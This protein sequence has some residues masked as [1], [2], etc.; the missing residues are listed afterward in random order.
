MELLVKKIQ[1]ESDFTE[2][3][4]ILESFDI[5]NPFYR[6]IDAN[7]N[8]LTEGNLRCFVMQNNDGKIIIVMPFLLRKIT[9][10]NQEKQY[11][12]VISPYGYS[13][14]L[15]N[16]TLSRGWL[17][18]FWELVD[19]WYRDNNVVSEFIRFNLCNNY[20][21]YTGVL[22][23]TLSNVRGAI[24]N[25]K[26]Q[27]SN[28]K[29]KVRNNYRR[30]ISNNLKIEIVFRDIEDSKIELFHGIYTKTMAR[31]HAER[32]YFYSIHCL[33]NIIKLSKGKCLI[34][35]TYFNNIAISTELILISG[36]TLFSYLGGTLSNY[37]NLR[38]NDFLKL[39]VI[40]WARKNH[41]DYYVL[42]GGRTN[43]DSLYK[44]KKSFFPNDK[45]SVYY[46]GRKIVNQKAYDMLCSVFK[47]NVSD[48]D[49]MTCKYF[50]A[51]RQ[52]NESMKRCVYR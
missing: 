44:Y 38:P 10:Q 16:R 40:K 5:T 48:M 17:L 50:P 51:Y 18:L 52:N 22:I 36:T 21:F 8:E 31:I 19:N 1:N 13:G 23:P 49:K 42:G 14:P 2:Y 32:E 46:T 29:Q 25:E 26:D 39:E 12:D 9:C 7:L 11:Y 33:K 27:W 41:M 37:F 45:D 30:S 15:F 20:D 35:F 47:T 34:A 4:E 24:I 28:F 6:I 3:L 43:Y